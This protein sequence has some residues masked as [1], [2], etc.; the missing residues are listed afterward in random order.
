MSSQRMSTAD[1]L[2]TRRQL[3]EAAR[4]GDVTGGGPPASGRVE[5]APAK[6]PRPLTRRELRARERARMT[7]EADGS[8]VAGVRPAKVAE[9][10]N[11]APGRL[12][13][14]LALPASDGPAADMRAEL[15]AAPPA[16]AELTA[17][18]EHDAGPAA[19]AAAS[20]EPVVDATATATATATPSAVADVPATPAPSTAKAR[21]AALPTRAVRSARSNHRWLP[22]LAVLGALG[23]LTTVIPLTGAAQPT[24]STDLATGHPVAESS[25]FDVLASGGSP[26]STDA[27]AALAADPLA[28]LRSLASASRSTADR[29]PT[30]CGSSPVE[31]NGVLASEVEAT[32]PDIVQP[33]A[34]GA[35]NLTSRYGYRVHPIFG[36]RSMHTGLDMSAAAGTPIHAVAEGTVTYAGTG[37]DG[38]SSMLVIVEHEVNGERFW[39]WYVHMYPN[40]VYVQAGQKVTAGEVIGAVG[41][42]GNSTGPHLHLEVHVDEA[43]TTV[44]PQTW[45]AE[46]AAV[47]LTSETLQCTQG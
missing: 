45:L 19:I 32:A 42:Y 28:S 8:P 34:E 31:A 23:A 20:T 11:D 2:P 39:T 17:A 33:L 44:D 38:R 26:V 18:P 5:A 29:A 37:K 47:P 43:L 1:A 3:R 41:S 10:S 35:Y 21:V 7:A 14:A 22:R 40:G 24:S 6:T 27:S 25:A 15:P 13:A 12:I 30:S 9:E 36:S 46:H 4:R 16:T